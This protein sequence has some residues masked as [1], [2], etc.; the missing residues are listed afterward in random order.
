M[1]RAIFQNYIFVILLASLVFAGTGCKRNQISEFVA[2]ESHTYFELMK[3][4]KKHKIYTEI[5]SNLMAFFVLD[6]FDNPELLKLIF[7]DSIQNLNTF[8]FEFRKQKDVSSPAKNFINKDFINSLKGDDSLF[9]EWK[10]HY[11]S[12]QI[13]EQKFTKTYVIVDTSKN[14]LQGTKFTENNK[15][16]YR[17]SNYFCYCKNGGIAGYCILNSAL[18]CALDNLCDLW[19]DCIETGNWGPGCQTS[20]DQAK[21]CLGTYEQ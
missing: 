3:D 7:K 11:S 6:E 14:N 20:L 18:R 15:V 16:V 8:I 4:K 2:S 1:E 21:V 13:S 12:F 5:N 19:K 9:K 10:N 17:I